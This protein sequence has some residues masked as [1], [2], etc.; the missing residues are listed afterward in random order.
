MELLLRD[1]RR[2][3]TGRVVCGIKGLVVTVAVEE[4]ISVVT[5]GEDEDMVVF[6]GVLGTSYLSDM[7]SI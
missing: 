2:V 3:V 4:A 6:G 1:K 7:V 5:E